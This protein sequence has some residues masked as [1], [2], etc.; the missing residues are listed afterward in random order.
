MSADNDLVG[1]FA[2]HRLRDKLIRAYR[3]TEIP[4]SY[5][6]CWEQADRD[7]DVLVA[8]VPKQLQGDELRA[9]RLG[10]EECGYV[11]DIPRGEPS[12]DASPAEEDDRKLEVKPGLFRTFESIASDCDRLADYASVCPESFSTLYRAAEHAKILRQAAAALRLE[13]E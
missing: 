6:G 8:E 10:C 13:S 7:I 3:A 5:V 11:S 4:A 2:R 12:D 1:P 9:T